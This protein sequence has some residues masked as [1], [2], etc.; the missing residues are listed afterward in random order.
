VSARQIGFQ[1]WFQIWSYSVGH[2]QLLL[3]S[4]KSAELLTRVD[5]LFK[6][7]VALKLP[8]A[9]AG[10]SVT[11]ASESEALKFSPQLGSSSITNRKVFDIRGSNFSG[12]VVAAGVFWHEDN[13]T[14]YDKSYF[15]DSLTPRTPE[16]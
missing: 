8:T 12:Y 9:F 7:V 5:V 10:L 2:A 3:R 6:D 1:R 13:G 15:E 11:E 14:Y 16:T 4:N